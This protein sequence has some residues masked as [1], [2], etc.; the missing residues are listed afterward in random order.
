MRVVG[1]ALYLA[2]SDL[3]EMCNGASWA[4]SDL[5]SARPIGIGRAPGRLPDRLVR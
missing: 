1:A 4:G 2:I 3:H 5:G